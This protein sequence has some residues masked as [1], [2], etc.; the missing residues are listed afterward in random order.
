MESGASQK[1]SEGFPGF[2]VSGLGITVLGPGFRDWGLTTSQLV[3]AVLRCESPN[4]KDRAA[5]T[6]NF[7]IKLPGYGKISTR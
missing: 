4:V 1:D 2:R 6:P 3:V 5:Q 7:A